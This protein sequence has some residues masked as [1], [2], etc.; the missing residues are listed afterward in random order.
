MGNA[1]ET[2]LGGGLA[3]RS[4]RGISAGMRGLSITRAGAIVTVVAWLAA[5]AAGAVA[6][7]TPPADPGLA[8]FLAAGGSLDDICADTHGGHG[9]GERHC[10]A[11]RLLGPVVLP[12]GPRAAA[13]RVALVAPPPPA[14]T[15]AA[16]AALRPVGAPRA[17]P[18][19]C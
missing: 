15:V 13:R 12:E 2:R 16:V 19:V 3:A 7:A 9:A 14:V 1:R 11:C 18:A 4:V 6:P 10:D 8:A 17:P 5:L